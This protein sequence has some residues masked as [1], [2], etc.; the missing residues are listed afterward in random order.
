MGDYV[1][2]VGGQER[3]KHIDIGKQFAREAIHNGHM[4]LIRVSTTSKLA[5]IDQAAAFTAIS[6]RVAGILGKKVTTS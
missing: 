3:A 5:D 6:A 4:K 1:L 2:L